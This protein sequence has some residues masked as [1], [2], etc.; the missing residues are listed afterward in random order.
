MYFDCGW[1]QVCNHFK[2]NT[3]NQQLFKRK[4][5]TLQNIH[6]RHRT[7][8]KDFFLFPYSFYLLQ[9]NLKFLYNILF[10]GQIYFRYSSCNNPQELSFINSG[11]SQL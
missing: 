1:Q 5:F 7:M 9:Y 11:F 10:C 8:K 6:K 4:E 3:R 2:N